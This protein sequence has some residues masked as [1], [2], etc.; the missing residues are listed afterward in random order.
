[1][2]AAG[3]LNGEVPNG[4]LISS[5]L[6]QPTPFP[7]SSLSSDLASYF[8]E[9]IEA[10]KRE[11][12]QSTHLSAFVPIHSAFPSITLDILPMFLGKANS[13]TWAVL[14]EI[15]VF[16]HCVQ[17][18]SSHSLLNILSLRLSL[19]LSQNCCCRSPH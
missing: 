19:P 11:L 15:V 7:L 6:R 8:S 16:I 10:V 4:S 13:F 12:P 14:V 3:P 17:L 1:M 18:L 2:V 9:K 5:L